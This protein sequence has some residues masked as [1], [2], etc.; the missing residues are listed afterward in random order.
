MSVRVPDVPDPFPQ[1]LED[2][3]PAGRPIIRCHHIDM[4]ANEFNTTEVSRRFRPVR[5]TAGTVPTIYGAD[6]DQ[7]ALSETV[8]HDVPVTGKAKRIQRRA[9]IHMV[10]STVTP[11]RDLRLVRLHGSGPRR[12]QASHANLIESSSR[13]Y[14]RTAMWG[15]A[16]YNVKPKFDG[17]I[18]R[19]R[20]FN[21]SYA[22]MLWGD[23]VLR[24]KHLKSDPDTA[25]LPLYL[26]EGLERVQQLADDCGITVVN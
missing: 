14:P 9:L 5:G 25:P 2:T 24:F 4:G 23:R 8:F 1:P 10:M 13:Q 20:Q 12:L 22:L 21:D 18:W 26:G 6:L 7:G 17:I 3:W 11:T 19:S 15:Q 16:L